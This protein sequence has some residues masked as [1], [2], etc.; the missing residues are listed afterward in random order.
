AY[1]RGKR[2]RQDEL[3]QD[4]HP[5]P[6]AKDGADFFTK[7]KIGQEQNQY[8]DRSLQQHWQGKFDKA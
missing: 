5:Y 2:D 6:V 8:Q 7:D 3:K 4:E 1:R